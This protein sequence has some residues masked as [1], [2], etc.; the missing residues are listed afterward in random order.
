MG[1]RYILK[2]L[3]DISPFEG[4]IDSFFWTSDDVRPITS[5]IRKTGVDVAGLVN[6][7]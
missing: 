6:R 7:F 4:T 3:E 5:N 1:H 2:K